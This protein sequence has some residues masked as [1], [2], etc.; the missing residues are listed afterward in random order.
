MGGYV[1][2]KITPTREL[3]YNEES[4][5][6][7]YACE[8]EQG[9]L[10]K[11]NT[12]RNISVKGKTVRLTLDNE[13]N[14]KLEEKQ[15]KKYGVYYE[16]VSIFEDIPTDI[17]K[18]KDYLRNLLTARQ[19]DALFSAYPNQDIID[20]IKHDQID[21]NKVKGIGKKIYRKIK[22]KIIQNL[23]YQQAYAFLSKYGVT[24]NMIIKLVKHF[25]SASLLIKKMETNPF[26]IT[27]VSGI[28]F[29]KA[30][31]IAMSMGYHP[32]G[33]F[34]I[35]AAIEYVVEEESNNGNTYVTTD[36]LVIQVEDLIGVESDL[37]N[38]K[39]KDTDSIIVIG[40]R[41]ALIKNYNAEKYISKRLKEIL[42][43]PIELDFDV[44]KFISE[45]EEKHGITLTDQQKSL[46]YNVKEN[47]VALLIGYAGTGK[48]QLTALLIDLLDQ[49][50]IGY[51]LTSPTGKAAKILSNYTKRTAET[52]HRAIGFGSE[53]DEKNMKFIDEEFI[54][55]DET[56]MVDVQL[57]AKLLKR[58]ANKKVRLL[59]V[60]D[61]FQISSIGAGRFL[62]DMINSGVIPTTKIDKVFRQ[63]E[64]SILD[65]ATKIRRKEKFLDNDEWGIKKLSDNCVI[66]CVP[67]EKV[68]GGYKYYLNEL[69]KEFNSEDITV[70]TPTKK[71]SLGTVEINNH[72]QEIVN[73]SDGIK[74]EKQ[75]GFDKITFRENDY[76]INTKNSYKLLDVNEREVDIV[77]GDIGKIVKIDL[78][79]EEVVVD[80][81]FTKIPFSFGQ[82]GQL[83][84]CWSMTIHKMQGSSNKAICVIADKAHKFQLNANLLYTAVTRSVDFLV[85]LSQAET[86][87]YAMRKI[88]NLQRDT[89]LGEFLKGEE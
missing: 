27:C 47:R 43:D 65:V 64:G 67:Q 55:V 71:S 41:V 66:A 13:Y 57:A 46:F 16:I 52:L 69:L 9:E 2:I 48:S 76:V 88:E 4:N 12:Y 72:I 6:G 81:E 89:F 79:E 53:Q 33:E 18:Q 38:E 74:F 21:L 20:L 84:H 28:G 80:F 8:T 32:K 29:K 40:E 60:G 61:D 75:T 70:V 63:K 25:K 73:P 62:Y 11:L 59:F 31:T 58:C 26:V 50:N 77:N 23:E 42:N 30:D 34:R 19:T 10:V 82:L 17:N 24:N 85:I 7:I 36:K 49:L 3:F 1:E 86:I 51:K 78:D 54:I 35:I 45:Q 5:Y 87:N 37:I 83:L 56:S 22:D 68:E 39:I 14:A 15:D 44:E